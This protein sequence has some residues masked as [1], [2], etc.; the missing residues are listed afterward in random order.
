MSVMA[1]RY[2]ANVQPLPQ[3]LIERSL[4]D[5][6]W[7]VRDAA[8]AAV[9]TYDRSRAA[10]LLLREL[11]SRYLAACRNAVQ[12]LEHA[13]RREA[14]IRLPAANPTGSAR[15]RIGRPS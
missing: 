5:P 2:L 15:E 7:L 4:N 10:A 9:Q 3:P 12:R 14:D 8:V 1:A 6:A 13:V 11:D